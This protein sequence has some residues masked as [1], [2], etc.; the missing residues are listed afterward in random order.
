MS[1]ATISR[2]RCDGLCVTILPVDENENLWLGVS[3][4]TG[5]LYCPAGHFDRF[6][7]SVNAARAE[8]R[9]EMG[10]RARSL[11]K[12]NERM[13]VTRNTCGR[14]YSFRERGHHWHLYRARVQGEPVLEGKAFETAYLLAPKKVRSL[15][16]RTLESLHETSGRTRRLGRKGTFIDPM[17]LPFLSVAGLIDLS[18]EGRKLVNLAIKNWEKA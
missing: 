12:L 3:P 16:Y 15:G 18:K 11:E 6:K 9:E 7:E 1:N 10:F 17:W 5:G 2:Q 8:L 13:L 4:K 14:P